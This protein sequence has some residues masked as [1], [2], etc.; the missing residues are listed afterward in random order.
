MQT[1][2]CSPQTRIKMAGKTRC[3]GCGGTGRVLEWNNFGKNQY[4]RCWNC[5]GSGSVRSSSS[6][7][8]SGG[9]GASTSSS[10]GWKVLEGIAAFVAFVAGFWYAWHMGYNLVIAFLLALVAGAI[11]KAF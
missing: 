1:I 8:Y 4:R 3:S 2:D 11:A 9:G 10:N 7:S 5:G 6:G